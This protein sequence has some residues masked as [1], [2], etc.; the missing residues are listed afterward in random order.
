MCLFLMVSVMMIYLHF[1]PYLLLIPPPVLLFSS[2]PT[3]APSPQAP[4]MPPAG[5]L[6]YVQ[7]RSSASIAMTTSSVASPLWLSP[8]QAVCCW[9]VMTTLTVTSGT[10]WRETE[11][12][13]GTKGRGQ[14][15][16]VV[17]VS[18]NL[19][20]QLTAIF[21]A[22]EG[23]NASFRLHVAGSAAFPWFLSL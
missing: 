1:C 4:M 2:F 16:I 12:V 5:C 19:K 17:F 20:V 3:A 7:T 15:L 14:V 11:Q 21:S 23:I 18:F 8:A 22:A 9:L 6:T 13:G 10:P